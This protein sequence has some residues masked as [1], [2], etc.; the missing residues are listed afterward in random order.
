[1]YEWRLLKN[2][3]VA[4]SEEL[5]GQNPMF[6]EKYFTLLRFLRKK[7]QKLLEKF[8]HMPLGIAMLLSP[9]ILN[10]GHHLW[11]TTQ[12]PN[13]PQKILQKL[14]CLIFKKKK[15]FKL[16]IL[17]KLYKKFLPNAPEKWVEQKRNEG[18]FT[19]KWTKMFIIS[20][21]FT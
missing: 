9:T 11:I 6:W 7:F 13:N 12:Y 5:G 16:I 1:V 18:S 21:F 20:P 15:L 19:C 3:P 2:M 8:L 14:F 4:Y 10:F 17:L